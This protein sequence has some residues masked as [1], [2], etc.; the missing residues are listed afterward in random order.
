MFLA[1]AN[2]G[3]MD[4]SANN[5]GLWS[6][7]V[8]IGIIAGMILL[9]NVLRRKIGIFRKSLMPT[10][11][12]AGFLLLILRSTG[13][14]NMSMSF[15]E[16]ITYHA[17]ALGF[18]AQ[19]LRIP[20]KKAADQNFVGLKSGAL[21][22]S[23]YMLQVII[24]LAISLILAFTLL[25]DL[26]GASGIL[27]AM[28]YGQGPGQA[29]NVGGTYELAGMLGGKSFGLSLAAAGY[30]CAC[31]VGVI[32]LNVVNRKGRARRVVNKDYL[33]GSVTVDAFQDANEIPVAESVD[34]LS[35]QAALVCLVYLLTFLITWGIVSLLEAFAPGLAASVSSLLWGFNFIIGSMVAMGCR[36]VISGL[37]KYKVMN[38]QYQNNYLLSRLSGLAF[39]V[40]IIAGIASIDISDLAGNWVP[41]ILMAVLGGVGTFLYL[42]WMC[43]KLYPSY[44]FEGFLSMYG[45]LTG[46]ISSG[47]L[48]LREIDPEF[49][50][51]ASNNLI[52]GSSFGIAFGFPLLLLV[53]FAAGSTTNALITLGI[54]AAYMGAL[55]LLMFKVGKGKKK[56][57]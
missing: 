22:V 14:L 23:T 21:I 57:Q 4:F 27:L 12:L 33:S 43:R 11:V 3:A 18:I 40:M 35:V 32:Y 29:N 48:L 51:P 6:P 50:T 42:L 9:A 44:H 13:V 49:K 31:V 17:L 37:R 1:A 30:L 55:M 20:E 7:I 56:K 19:S 52:V 10:A 47:V 8:Q 36:G 5:A 38:R 2:N 39:D 54:A 16:T 34:R 25:P 41:F 15:L 26:F 53:N 46:T 45:M 24:G 28:A